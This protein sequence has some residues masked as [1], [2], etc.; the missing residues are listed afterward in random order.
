MN[1]SWELAAL[2]LLTAVSPPRTQAQEETKGQI[3]P[4]AEKELRA[5]FDYLAQAP[6]FIVKAELWRERVTDTGEKLQFTR[7]MELDVRRPDHLHADVRGTVSHRQF[8]YEGKTLAVFD[9]RR[10]LYSTVDLPGSL[11]SA[12]DSAQK[13]YGIDLPLVDLVVSKPFDSAVAKVEKGR[14]LGIV[15]VLGVDCHH[16]AFT[17]E[18]IDWQIWI[19]SGA[20]P[21]IRK[22][23]LNHKIDPGEPQFTALLTYWDLN[24]RIADSAFA[25]DASPGATRIPMQKAPPEQADES[26]ARSAAAKGSTNP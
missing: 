11:D 9:Q 19:S 20:Q 25:F 16:L 8:W 24:A 18:N 10:N 5:A 3:E 23:V 1:I 4:R 17:Q 15:P 7:T 6:S 12:F 13:D 14:Y 21:L 2:A 22:I 26:N